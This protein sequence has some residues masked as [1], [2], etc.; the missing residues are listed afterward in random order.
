MQGFPGKPICH[1]GLGPG[2]VALPG[3]RNNVEQTTP[4]RLTLAQ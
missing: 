3:S 1:G 2:S 4:F